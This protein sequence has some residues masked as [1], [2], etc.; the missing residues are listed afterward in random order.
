MLKSFRGRIIIILAVLGLSAGYLWTRGLKLGLDLQGGIHLVLE[1]DDPD[2]TLTPERR[3]D[4]ID[5]A[6]RIIRTRVDE[7]GVEE[8]LIQ[9]SGADRIIVELAGLDDESRAKEI[10][11]QQAYL[12]WKLVL[13]TTE[14]DPALERL[15]RAVVVAIGE[16]GLREMGRATEVTE[17]GT[18]IEQLLFSDPEDTVAAADGAA[19]AGDAATAD[20]PAAEDEAADSVEPEEE[21]LNLRPFTGLLNRGDVG[22]YTVDAADVETADDFMALPEFQRAMPRNV[23]LQW[24]WD[25]IPIGGR[26]YRE[27]YVLEEEPFLTGDQL[28]DATAN[29][30][31]QF[32]QP[33]VLFE[34]NRRGGR[35][36]QQLTG[37]HIGDRIAI[38]LDGE[39]VSAP[40]VRD[41]I[42]SRGSIDLGSA[43]MSEATDLALVLRAGALPA[44]LRIMEERAVGPSLGQDS[45]DQGRIAGI[46][47]IVLV[48]V[49]MIL[50]Y[51]VAGMLA[52]TALGFYLVLVLGGLAALNATLT[53]PGIAGLILSIGM[54]VDA[55]V[56]IF[57][58]IR[59]ELA[60]RRAPRTAVDEGFGNALSAIV[61]ANL[62]TLITGLILFQFGTGP[63]R[64]FAVT[65]CIGIVASFF[66]ALYV[67]RTLFLMYLSGKRGSDPVSI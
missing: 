60:A 18:S 29:R 22:T 34:L 15:D 36:F 55:N 35:A 46:V 50:Y 43:D 49:V 6:E 32:N 40:V 7:F 39:V 57:E 33:Q 45:V 27:L 10:I 12:E 59:E 2:E 51:K 53:L 37:A 54:A 48:I 58:R 17:T 62:T 65:L 63:V 61:D 23:S 30:D 25:S 56:L 52:I 5:R 20:A 28:D 19:E 38:V 14:I 31:Q 41:R 4:A 42:G 44:P 11:N 13:E 67:T 24:G 16:E 66:S 8:P 3:A 47:G 1:I 21:E 26:F 9:K 64:G